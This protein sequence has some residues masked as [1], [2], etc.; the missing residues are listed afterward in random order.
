LNPNKYMIVN[1]ENN[2]IKYNIIDTFYK[3]NT[4]LYKEQ[5]EIC[6]ICTERLCNIQTS[7]NHTFCE[8]CIQIWFKSNQDK[9]CPNCQSCLSNAVFQP[10]S[11]LL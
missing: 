8:S 4:I 2:I 11:Y 10:I 3:S 9:K 1:V 5:I 7:C 6:P